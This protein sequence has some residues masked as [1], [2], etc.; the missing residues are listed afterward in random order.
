M[1]LDFTM[2]ALVVVALHVLLFLILFALLGGFWLFRLVRLTRLRRHGERAEGMI[3]SVPERAGRGSGAG[4]APPRGDGGAKQRVVVRF[5]TGDGRT[6]EAKR[7]LALRLAG[8]GPG[9]RVTAVYDPDR[10]WRADIIESKARIRAHQVIV[11][12]AALVCFWLSGSSIG[13]F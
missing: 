2:V 1:D 10:P 3:V 9:R 6:V 7:G 8:I 4:E 12:F 13:L 11:A 5:E